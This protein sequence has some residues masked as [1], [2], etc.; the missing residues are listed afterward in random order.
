VAA[1]ALWITGITGVFLWLGLMGA[2][3][4]DQFGRDIFGQAVCQIAAYSLGLF[5]LLR[6]YAPETSIRQFLALR[7]THL[8]FYPLA[9]LLG[10]AAALPANALFEA[11]HQLFPRP[12]RATEIADLF[13][14]A[15][16]SGRIL[17]AVA[18]MFIGP[19]VEE[20]MFRGALFGP[21]LRGNRLATTVVTTAVYFALVHLD[22]YVLLPITLVGL[23]LGYLRAMSGS[24]VPS[25]LLHIA[26]NAIPLAFLFATPSLEQAK[27]P[28]EIPVV[29]TI[30]C[31]VACFCLLAAIR[32]LGKHTKTALR[33]RRQDPRS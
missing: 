18:V 2:L 19:V 1:A 31:T 6:V 20:V 32:H 23:L 8:G 22:I 13:Y 3:A 21:L 12:E 4:H 14:A 5:G 26:F 9:L 27:Q 28:S 33:A 11:I 15:S 25:V 30:L 7:R 29:P 16:P 10:A 17:I 24:L